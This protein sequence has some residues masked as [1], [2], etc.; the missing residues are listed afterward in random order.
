MKVRFQLDGGNCLESHKRRR[1][2]PKLVP[3]SSSTKDTHEEE[4][5]SGI[6]TVIEW[7]TVDSQ[8]S[9]G[10]TLPSLDSASAAISPLSCCSDSQ[11]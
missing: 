7:H 11:P 1:V 5:F 9:Q 10:L 2:L 8:Y 3:Q 6:V 4:N